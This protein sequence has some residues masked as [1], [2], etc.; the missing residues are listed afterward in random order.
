MVFTQLIIV[1]D[2]KKPMQMQLDEF[3]SPLLAGKF[4]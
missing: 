2:F 3:Y 1:D 4:F